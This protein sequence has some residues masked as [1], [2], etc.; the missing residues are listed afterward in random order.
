[1]LMDIAKETITLSQLGSTRVIPVSGVW[2]SNTANRT[3]VPEGWM[4]KA[5]HS[6]QN[7]AN[8]SISHHLAT[9]RGIFRIIAR[10]G[11]SDQARHPIKKLSKRP[12]IL[13]SIDNFTTSKTY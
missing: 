8:K 5:N 13:E 10:A 6:K 7:D 3:I 11:S 1:M 4:V 2:L 9:K 12:L